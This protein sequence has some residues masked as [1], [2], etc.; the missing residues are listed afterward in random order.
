VGLIVIGVKIHNRKKAI[1]EDCGKIDSETNNIIAK[2]LDHEQ[3]K[4]S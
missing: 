2:N 3:E 1:E 4:L